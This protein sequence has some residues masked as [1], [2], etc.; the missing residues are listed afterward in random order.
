MRYFSN[1]FK[2]LRKKYPSLK[3]EFQ[4][5]YDLLLVDANQ[6]EPLGAGLFKIRLA[7]ESKGKGKS[8]GLRVV[9][10]LVNETEIGTDIY[11]V[12]IYDKSAVENIDK[13]LL[14]EL[15]KGL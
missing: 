1:H 7:N 8:G 10:Y 9:T 12:T 15:V 11:L 6:G 2:K 3:A 4:A 14:L 13:T 5:L